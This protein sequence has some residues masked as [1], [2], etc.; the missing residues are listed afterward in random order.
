MMHQSYDDLIC[1][2]NNVTFNGMYSL[3]GKY[4]CHDCGQEIDPVEY[5]KMKGMLNIKLM[6]YYKEYPYKLDPMWRDH[7]RVKDRYRNT[8]I[9]D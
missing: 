7:W 8:L 9:W 1:E 5:A 6:D 4:K 3:I 2:H